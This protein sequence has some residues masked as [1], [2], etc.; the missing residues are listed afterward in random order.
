MG[1]NFAFMHGVRVVALLHH[2]GSY[3]ATGHALCKAAVGRDLLVVIIR[4][5]HRID[6]N[7]LSCVRNN[8][9]VSTVISP[10]GQTCL[11]SIAWHL[12]QGT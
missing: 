11:R 12:C 2:S 9:V 8:P 1:G 6:P 10:S 3:R 5:T 4:D 7:R